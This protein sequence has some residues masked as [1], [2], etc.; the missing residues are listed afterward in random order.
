MQALLKNMRRLMV[1]RTVFCLS[2]VATALWLPVIWNGKPV[3]SLYIFG[4]LCLM[5]AV[6]LMIMDRNVFV[7]LRK[8]E[9]LLRKRGVGDEQITKFDN[10]VDEIGIVLAEMDQMLDKLAAHEAMQQEQEHRVMLYAQELEGKTLELE[11]ARASAD[12]ANRMK[13]DFLATMSHEIRTPLN[14]IIGMTELMLET[15]LVAKQ[16]HYMETVLSSAESLLVL[17]NDIL[18]LS[19]VESGKMDLEPLFF[20]MLKLVRETVDLF[21]IKAHEKAITLSLN[22]A[23]G[24]PHYVIADPVRVRQI[25]SNLISNAIK[26]TPK[27]QV[28]V[29]VEPEAELNRDA[30]MAGFRFKIIDSGIGISR[31]AQEK[32]FEKFTQADTSTTRKYGGSGLGLSI[33]KN[34]AEMMG[35]SIGMTSQLDVGSTFWFTLKLRRAVAPLQPESE[36]NMPM[37]DGGYSWLGRHV[38]LV[39]DSA[40]NQMYVR[41]V[42][43]KLGCRVT[44]AEHGSEAINLAA[45]HHDLT[46]ILMDCHMPVMDGFEA[47][48]KLRILQ[49]TEKL[50]TI[51]II[52]LTA[53]AMKGDRERCLDAGMNDYLSK[54]VRKDDLVAMLNKWVKPVEATASVPILDVLVKEELRATLGVKFL[55]FLKTFLADTETRLTLMEKMFASETDVHKIALHAHSISSSSAYIGARQV[56]EIAGQIEIKVGEQKP[57]ATE[58]RGL[59]GN[60]QQVFIATKQELASEL[61]PSVESASLAIA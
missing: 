10:S 8:I 48:R 23:P 19:K 41:E 14:G 39:E 11:S 22:Y 26:F 55:P 51:P 24:A 59:F 58:I 45:Q 47:A 13:G 40:V 44:V 60:L 52:A 36:P 18:D 43:Q 50:P 12:L 49:T 35:G 34:L 38:L 20:D 57:D 15:P 32:I 5:V 17:I 16:K 56:S 27:G 29:T 33:C 53:L 6:P 1:Q 54:P 28:V 25:L 42:L 7:P 46:V 4:A 9:A 61:Q 37:K 3:P 30:G 31:T 21:A 2:I